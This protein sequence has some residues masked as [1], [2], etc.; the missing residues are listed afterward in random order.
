MPRLALLGSLVLA[1]VGATALATPS[2][3]RL[4]TRQTVTGDAVFRGS[5][6]AALGAD[7]LRSAHGNF[8]VNVAAGALNVQSNQIVQAAAS[9][10]SV[11]TRQVVRSAAAIAGASSAA[12]GE[13]ALMGASGNIGV[14]VA[15]G[16]AN[17]QANALA[18]H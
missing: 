18:I 12:L 9:Q 10:V 6:V 4:S 16:A 1:A 3:A 8:G 13:R 11:D 7:A 17:A 5:P 2:A 15:A 14:N